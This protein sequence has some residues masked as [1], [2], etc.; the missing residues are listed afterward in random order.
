[1]YDI[2]LIRKSIVPERHKRVLFSVMSF[3]ALVFAVTALAVIFFSMSNMRVIDVYARELDHLEE[4][5]SRLYPGTP[6]HEE[7]SIV[8]SRMQ[9]ELKEI[10]AGVGTRFGMTPLWEGIAEAVPDSVWLTSVSLKAPDEKSRGKSEGGLVLQGKAITGGGHRGSALI[11][12]FAQEIQKSDL[13]QS[14]VSDA[15]FV[16]TG[17]DA[18]GGIEVI[19]FEI[20][21][22]LH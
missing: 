1:V 8:F 18:I 12:S 6:T 22:A 11:R 17:F 21:C 2:N 16:E 3:T 14:Y 13:L 20:T 4:D 10:S 19:G 9:P 7:L 15:K 5:L